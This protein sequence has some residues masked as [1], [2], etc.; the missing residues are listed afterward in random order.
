MGQIEVSL[1]E[2]CP[3]YPGVLNGRLHC[4]LYYINIYLGQVRYWAL[5]DQGQGHCRSSNG[6]GLDPC[7]P[8]TLVPRSTSCV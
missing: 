3:E 8:V 4:T 1:L 6:L 5:S 7:D 2:R